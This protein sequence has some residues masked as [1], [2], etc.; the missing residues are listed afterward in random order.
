MPAPSPERVGG[1]LGLGV[2]DVD[3]WLQGGLRRDGVHEFYAPPDG[4]GAG[5]SAF[6]LLVGRLICGADLPLIWLRKDRGSRRERPYAPGLAELGIDP[7]AVF[8][9]ELRDLSDLLVAT[10]ESVRHGGAG[11][12]ILEIQG[13]ARLLDLTASRRLALAAERSG[14]AVLL[15]RRSARPVASAAHT[16]WQVSAA[17]SP[18]LPA[19]AP[20]PPVFDLQLLRQRGG[21][22]GLHVQLEWNREQAVF[23]T[24]I[25]GDPSAVPAGGMADRGR[26]R[27]A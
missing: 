3:R 10:A 22:E 27:A 15:V 23:R 18:A 14:T 7:D 24:P 2:P 6:A 21:P 25:Y 12:V 13:R 26:R 4:E 16:R 19:N 17:P 8:L 11:A 20:G 9:V 1:A 5:A